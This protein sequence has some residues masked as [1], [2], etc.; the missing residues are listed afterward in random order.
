[1][2]HR[3]WIGWFGIGRGSGVR[4]P[5]LRKAS[6]V[7]PP[8]HLCAA[9][10]RGGRRRCLGQHQ[11]RPQ[12]GLPCGISW[13]Y[14]AV[15]KPACSSLSCN[16]IGFPGTEKFKNLP[17]SLA[18]REPNNQSRTCNLLR[19]ATQ[20]RQP[21]DHPFRLDTRA[22]ADEHEQER[23]LLRKSD[24]ATALGLEAFRRLRPPHQG[25]AG[26]SPK[27]FV[28]PRGHQY[29]LAVLHEFASSQ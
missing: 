28:E 26:H 3:I 29:H 6:Y 11:E 7:F 21:D 10:R 23:P 20:S 9:G 19:T 13:A 24:R 1:M 15:T 2:L 14:D 4:R 18:P 5:I 16:G 17:L 27:L 12:A 8:A 22:S 25:S